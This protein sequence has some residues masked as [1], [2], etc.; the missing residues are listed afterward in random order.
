MFCS[1]CGT[2][3]PDSASFCSAC[4]NAVRAG[5]PVQ[6][7][8]Q[9]TINIVNSNTF[10]VGGGYVNKSKW[11]AFFLCL[12]LGC[13]GVHRFYVGKTGTGLLWLFTLGFGGFGAFIDLIIILCDG[14]RD[15]MGQPLV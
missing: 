9:P 8:Q 13:L 12:F 6:P 11:T 2:Q 1:K 15:K 14:F 10:S 3:L 4:G 5:A 7:M